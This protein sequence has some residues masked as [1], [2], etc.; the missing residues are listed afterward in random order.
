L[1]ECFHLIFACDCGFWYLFIG[2]SENS[3]SRAAVI[4][5]NKPIWSDEHIV[6]DFIFFVHKA[7]ILNVLE[8]LLFH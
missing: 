8:Y 7:D 4:H 1:P 3:A 5:F 2:F 6:A